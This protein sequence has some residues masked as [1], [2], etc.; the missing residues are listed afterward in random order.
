MFRLGLRAHDFGCLRPEELAEVLAAYSPDCVQLALSKAFCD[1]VFAIGSLDKQYARS[2][3][4]I[5]AAK[6]ISISVLGCY[7]NPVHPD[8]ECLERQLRIFEEHLRFAKDFGC[9]I[10][11]T[12]T[13]SLNPDCSFNPQTANPKVFDT[14]RFSLERLA[15]VAEHYGIIIGIEPVADQHTLSS[16][17]KTK[18]LLESIDSPSLGVIFDPVNLISRRGLAGS[19]AEF[20]EESFKAFGTRIVAVHLKDF[21]FESGI[22]SEPLPVGLGYFDLNSFFILLRR[23]SLGVD[24]ILENTSRATAES[25]L[26][27]VVK[28]AAMH[29]IALIHR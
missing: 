14:L 25:A 21:R 27:H 13:G 4:D 11:G 28:V 8:P 12:E 23:K 5:F 17:E 26:A 18:V 6:G 3:R 22:K 10:V 19:Q 1:T 24:I 29:D 15:R 16:I 7:I 9:K 20:L 2:V